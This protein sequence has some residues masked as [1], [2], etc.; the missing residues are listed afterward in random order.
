[1][2]KHISSLVIALVLNFFNASLS[3]PV[4]YNVLSLGAKPDG[5]TDS[6]KSF[7]SAWTAA[8]CSPRPA[9]VYI[10][11]ARKVL[12]SAGTGLWACKASSKLC[13]SGATTLGFVNSNNIVI[14][15]LTSLNSQMFHIVINGCQNVKLRGVKVLASGTSPNTD[16]IQ[17][18]CGCCSI[19]SLGKDLQEAAVQNVTIK[20]VTFKGTQNG[21]RIKTWG[22]P[23]SGFVQ[24]VLFQHAVMIN[25]QNP[26]VIDQT[27][28]PHNLNCPGQVSGVIIRDVTYQDIHGTSA[29]PVAVKFDCSRNNPC[30]G[31]R[32]EDVKLTYQNQPAAASCANAGGT[33][34][35]LVEPTSCLYHRT[36]G[37]ICRFAG[38]E[39]WH[40]EEN[41][42]MNLRL[43]G[44]GIKG[45]IPRGLEM[46]SSLIGLD[47][48]EN[49]LF[50]AIPSDISELIP[51]VTTL[52]LSSNNISGEIPRSIGK[53][54]YLN[55]L[56][57]ENNRLE[58]HIPQEV[59]MLGRIKT[60]SVANNRLSGPVPTFSPDVT[61]AAEDY[62]K[63]QELCGYPLKLCKANTDYRDSLLR[64]MLQIY[65]LEKFA[66]RIQFA[67]LE[68][69]TKNFNEANRI[70]KL[71]TMYKASLPNGS[72]LAVK[73]FN[74]SKRSEKKFI[75][76]VMTLG[77]LR[78]SNLMPLIGFSIHL[79][80]R[81]L[82]Y[83]YM[84]NGNL[85]EW[86]HPVEGDTKI[87]EWPVR[88][89][90]AVGLARGLA[91][92][93][94]NKNLRV[95][96]QNIS[97]E[98]ILLDHTFETKLS[99]FG[100]ATIMSSNST[101]S[102][103]K[104]LG[105]GETWVLG[106]DRKDVYGFGIVL[107]ELV[108]REEPIKLIL[109]CNNS[110]RTLSNFTS[111]YDA[112]DE[113][114]LGQGYEDEINQFLVIAC[115][116]VLSSLDQRPSMLDVYSEMR[117]IAGERY[118]LISDSQMLMQNEIVAADGILFQTQGTLV[119]SWDY[120]SLGNSGFW[121]LFPKVSRL[122]VSG[123]TVDGRGAGFWACR[124]TGSNCPYGTR[125]QFWSKNKSVT[126]VH[127]RGTSRTEAAVRFDCSSSNPCRDQIAG[128]NTF[129]SLQSNSGNLYVTMLVGIVVALSSQ[130]VVWG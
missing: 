127:I 35:G 123:G 103:R 39:C 118:G 19:G 113:S 16:C 112:I 84:Q 20:I 52:D 99:N 5:K 78:H 105:S 65:L 85:H 101:V 32:L 43:S 107:L 130:E 124:R 77:R 10:C 53:L 63:N 34:S 60:F 69:A 40:S 46:C 42:V 41:K 24:G 104:L 30:S 44:M 67:V 72:I 28:C 98:C 82:V 37:F 15:G 50:G 89:K 11:A 3:I 21:L 36:E 117:T 116:C 57:L 81:L 4:T 49:A 90:I 7:L 120:R 6:T 111:V 115:K 73:R 62:A 17:I 14:S 59:G 114:L 33:S 83:K 128:H 47:L 25:V 79:K 8:C 66:T 45:G 92:L 121:I 80:E 71:G 22:R 55:V 2:A 51:Y 76:E 110:G 31:I 119:A 100:E 13:P 122:T 18:I 64:G 88:V 58:G 106:V 91:W 94:N 108:T 38:V 26:I 96:H 74:N 9:T 125:V 129:H 54:S 126:Y 87:M 93:H 97:S 109:F 27:Y 23:S 75:S 70:G 61:I 29:T 48:S 95:V 68:K 102:S 86:L 12:G 56:K 1:M